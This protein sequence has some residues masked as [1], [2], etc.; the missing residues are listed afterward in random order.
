MLRINRQ[1][2]ESGVALVIV[3][4]LITSLMGLS[5]ALNIAIQSLFTSLMI[6][7]YRIHLR[8]ALSSFSH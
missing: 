6:Q 3:L 1:V 5:L 8:V 7:E 2:Q 4:A